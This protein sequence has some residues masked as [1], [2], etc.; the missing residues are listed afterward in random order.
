MDMMRQQFDYNSQLAARQHLWQMEANQKAFDNEKEW[1]LDEREYNSPYNQLQRLRAAG[2]NPAL[3]VGNTAMTTQT[4]LNMSA[5]AG[6]GASVGS[7]SSPMAQS[8]ALPELTSI[9]QGLKGLQLAD[10]Q[11][12]ESKARQQLLAAQTDNVNTDTE[13]TAAGRDF[14]SDLAKYDTEFKKYSAQSVYRD[15][16]EKTFRYEKLMPVQLKQLLEDVKHAAITNRFD[17]ESFKDRLN[18]IVTGNALKKAQTSYYGDLKRN[19]DSEISYRDYAVDQ[20]EKNGASARA[21]QFSQEQINKAKSQILELQKSANESLSKGNYLEALQK[22]MMINFLQQAM[23]GSLMRVPSPLEFG[24]DAETVN[25]SIGALG[26]M[27]P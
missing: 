21:L 17:T 15:I 3:G 19:I 4:P 27:I 11:I 25:R 14:W 2:I 13:K 23:Q 9:M 24:A 1:A 16:L 12:N 22:M 26:F 20:M 7:S 5:D 10:Q 6:G 18:A 8:A